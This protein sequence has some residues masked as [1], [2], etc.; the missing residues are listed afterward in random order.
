MFICVVALHLSQHFFLSCRDAISGVEILLS[1][2][3]FLS[4]RENIC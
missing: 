2:R 1:I 4:F 3:Y